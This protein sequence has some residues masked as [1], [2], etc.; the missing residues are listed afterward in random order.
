MIAFKIFNKISPAYLIEKFEVFKTREYMK[1]REGI[2]R[3]DFMFCLCLRAEDKDNI[4]C[5]IKK[6]WNSLPLQIRNSDSL[7]S[8][9][10]KLKTYLFT[11]S[12][13]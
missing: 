10:C 12:F 11:L 13:S 4:I 8:F 3:D 1:S 7:S 6:E 5:L 2:G 9:K